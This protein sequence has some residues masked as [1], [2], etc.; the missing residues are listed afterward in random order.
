M[1]KNL[2]Y[3]LN[4]YNEQESSHFHHVI[5]LLEELASQNVK[6]TLLIEKAYATPV[7][8]NKNIEIVCL[9]KRGVS[10]LVELFRYVY[11]RCKNQ[12][13]S[14]FIRI[15]SISAV[16]SSLASCF[17][18]SK[19]FF[20]QS[21]TT[22]E[23]DWSQ[24][25]SLKK[26]KWFFKSYLPSYTARKLVDR[27]VTGPEYMADYYNRVV[28][29]DKGKIRVLYNDIEL[30]RFKK[31]EGEIGSFKDSFYENMP[32]ALNKK[33]ILLV[34]KMSPVRRTTMY[35]PSCLVEAYHKNENVLFLIVGG[36]AEL[37]DI[38]RAVKEQ[39]MESR[40]KFMG[41]IPNKEIQKLYS[42]ASIFIH[43][44]YNEG[45][46][47]VMLEAMAS[48]L[49]F[50]STDAGGVFDITPPELHKFISPRDSIDQFSHNLVSL[51][52]DEVMWE[53][54]GNIAQSYVERFDT[55]VIAKM[56]KRV[57]F[58]D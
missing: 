5:N 25:K 21:G 45:F 1:S 35:I 7:F 40:V 48:G 12:Q 11:M 42:L 52:E 9:K 32:E 44:T 24:P 28:G 10:R 22:H 33:I 46:P 34:H 17:S 56:Y 27:F 2:I 53:K 39:G 15:T 41:E 19:V 20:W 4:S 55:P 3:I 50:V 16:I 6:I 47:R 37:P 58:D 23:W 51:L 26:L 38:Q 31:A 8:S 30:K 29:L 43:P 36:G 57:L 14:I 49:P 13:C 54:Y 18:S